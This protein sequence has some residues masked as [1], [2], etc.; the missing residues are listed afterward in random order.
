MTHG[1]R[2]LNI[3]PLDWRNEIGI[4]VNSFVSSLEDTRFAK[5]LTAKLK[6]LDCYV[7]FK[8][9]TI[10][11]SNPSNILDQLHLHFLKPT[12]GLSQHLRTSASTVATLQIYFVWTIAISFGLLGLSISPRGSYP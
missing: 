4:D 5:G 2:R 6:E 9:F 1:S 3:Q 11:R 7:S 10:P 8:S 12:Q